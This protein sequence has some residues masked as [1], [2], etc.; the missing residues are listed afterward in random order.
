MQVVNGPVTSY[1]SACTAF[2][3]G[4]CLV[5]C[6][7]EQK[8]QEQQQEQQPA[9]GVSAAA[10]PGSCCPLLQLP[11]SHG[12]D[13]QQLALLQLFTAHVPVGRNTAVSLSCVYAS[14]TGSGSSSSSAGTSHNSVPTLWLMTSSQ[15]GDAAGAPAPGGH[16]QRWLHLPVA[17]TLCGGCDTVSS[18]SSSSSKGI[19]VGPVLSYE[20]SLTDVS[21][22]LVDGAAG[23]A[24]AASLG[25]VQL[26]QLPGPLKQQPDAA[27]PENSEAAAAAAAA[28][29]AGEPV[30]LC[31]LNSCAATSWLSPLSA[32][33]GTWQWRKAEWTVPVSAGSTIVGVG[34]AVGPG[35]QAGGDPAG[36]SV[37][38][39][40]GRVDMAV[41]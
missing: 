41:V 5:L 13:G 35:L 38:G 31:G 11:A 30:G 19:S 26:L 3:G 17:A 14:P 29:A 27:A 21:V 22:L 16:T 36:A 39:L 2:A 9:T 37:L 34:V 8:Q 33:V 4:S 1:L 28:A 6:Q 12:G 40:L 23:G 7:Q 24:D 15:G 20:G 18:S 32:E 10:S 25:R